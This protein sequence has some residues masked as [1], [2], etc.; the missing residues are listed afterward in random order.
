MLAGRGLLY[1]GREAIDQTIPRGR[2]RVDGVG[3]LPRKRGIGN[4]NNY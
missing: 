1:K 4:E 3:E 2:R